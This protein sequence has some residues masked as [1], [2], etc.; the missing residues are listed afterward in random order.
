MSYYYVSFDEVY[1]SKE[2]HTTPSSLMGLVEFQK[3][4]KPMKMNY[5]TERVKSFGQD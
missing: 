4:P 1:S 3:W 5:F 2:S